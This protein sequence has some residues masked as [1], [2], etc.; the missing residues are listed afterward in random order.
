MYLAERRKI[1]EKVTH[2][3]LVE[4]GRAQANHKKP[5]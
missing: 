5:T 1:K 2:L 4:E 3:D